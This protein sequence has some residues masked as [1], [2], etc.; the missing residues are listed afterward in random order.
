MRLTD[1]AWSYPTNLIRPVL[2][3][4]CGIA[5]LIW[6]QLVP[7]AAIIA[8]LVL[9]SCIDLYVGALLRI[10]RRVQAVM[11]YARH[12]PVHVKN[13]P[14]YKFVD[15]VQAASWLAEQERRCLRV[16]S[17]HDEPLRAVFRFN[18]RDES[19]RLGPPTLISRPIGPDQ[20]ETF[21]SN[22]FWLNPHSVGGRP[23]LLR[24][25]FIP[26][27]D[28]VI[29]EV[30]APSAVAAADVMGQIL[31]RAA[32]ASIYRGHLLR[33]SFGHETRPHFAMEETMTRID[34]DFLREAPV[35]DA[36]I[37][38][39]EVTRA[40]LEHTIVDFHHRRSALM[41]LGLP[42]KRGVLFYG[43]PGTGKTYTCRYLAHQLAPVT[44]I[45]ATGHA[46][47]RMKDIC[48]LAA[49]FQPA[50]VLLE[51][52]DLVFAS[53]EHNAYNTILGEFMDE[54]DGFGAKHHVLFV[55]TTNAIE[56]VEAAIKDRPGRI[57]QCVYFGPPGPALRRHYL[58]RML[59]A[60]PLATCQV[61]TLVAK[62]EGVSQ[63]FLKELLYRSV[64][65]ASAEQPAESP[66]EV[67]LVDTHLE[68]AL[69]E[70][71]AGAGPAG[72]RIIGFR[73]E[74]A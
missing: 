20:S 4:V 8:V 19:R 2:L 21:P 5:A 73:V 26:L 3:L 25:A 42:G 54:L 27:R 46:L 57:S 61:D 71:L 29:I 16:T 72:R 1:I 13:F 41:R 7:Y 51:D 36:S 14:A 22:S 59:E 56:R 45:V 32:T 34:L 63:A 43:P 37:V 55:L 68:E 24:V 15:I 39:D 35:T 64:Q 66:A 48:A 10:D 69:A 31:A 62:T 53:R 49:M 47:M 23:W 11:P 50:L 58:E 74:G 52:V 38:L 65:R 9:L 12:W 67:R 30:A 6:P 40:T 17:E 60:Y 33:V 70:M 44:T 28:M 18:R